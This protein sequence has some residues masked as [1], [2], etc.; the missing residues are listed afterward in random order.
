MNFI[1][2]YIGMLL[3]FLLP[4]DIYLMKIKNEIIVR[5]FLCLNIALGSN[6]IFF[7]QGNEVFYDAK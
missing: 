7:S 1:H 6:S 4:V 2:F 3:Y 5:I